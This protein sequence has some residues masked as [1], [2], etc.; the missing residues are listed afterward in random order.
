M[1][2][3][4]AVMKL[5]LAAFKIGVGSALNILWLV[6]IAFV[7]GSGVCALAPNTLI[8]DGGIHGANK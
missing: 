4:V 5:L 3:L 6:G 1:L 8:W 7:G 2:E